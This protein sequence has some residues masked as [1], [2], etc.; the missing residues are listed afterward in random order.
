M[1]KYLIDVNLP[2]F[3]SLWHST[4]YIHQKDIDDEWSDQVIWDYAKSNN[5]TI[6]TKDSDF[7]TKILFNDPPPR[8]IHIRVGNLLMKDFF[9]CIQNCWL[10]VL[11]LNKTNK[12]VTVF[13]NRIEAIN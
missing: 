3:F 11:E 6:I 12:H 4:D 13:Y 5:L 8:V 10:D 1:P 2:Y 7:S 9:S